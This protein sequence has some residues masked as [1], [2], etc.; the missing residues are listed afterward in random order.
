MS[1]QTFL[2]ILISISSLLI[3][4]FF[5]NI[6]Y[7]TKKPKG[8]KGT[9]SLK[10]SEDF[11][12]ELERLI[13]GEIKR[14]VLET[15]QRIIDGIIDYYKGQLDVLSR[16]VENRMNNLSKSFEKTL[17]LY[18][19]KTESFSRKTESKTTNL[20]K[21]IQKEIS[22]FSESCAQGKDLILQEAKKKAS[23]FGQ[24]L[25]K[26]IDQI[27]QSATKSI[28]QEISKT[29]KNIED[30]KKEKLKEIDEKIYQ[31]IG[32]VAK[33]TIGKAIDISDHEQLVM[34]SLEKAKKEKIL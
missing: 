22:S 14:T 31:I 8:E 27:S 26:K 20:D 29:Q 2:I 5:I 3:I 4:L 18:E 23:E 34:E 19:E 1:E 30:Y 6:Y 24:D 25:D 33:K 13:E 16:E 28:N 17:M 15:N 21:I 9:L 32:E 12:R 11:Q 10:F 7:L